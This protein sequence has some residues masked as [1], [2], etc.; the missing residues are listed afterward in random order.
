M[1]EEF[2]SKNDPAGGR[3][4]GNIAAL[5]SDEEA[6]GGTSGQD[7]KP[8]SGGRAVCLLSI[9]EGEEDKG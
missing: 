3:G 9:C 6:A 8:A 4:G 2:G 7:I 5:S 1:Y